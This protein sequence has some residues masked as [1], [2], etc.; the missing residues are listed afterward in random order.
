MKQIYL[1]SLVNAIC[2]LDPF[3]TATFNNTTVYVYMQFDKRHLIIDYKRG[4]G[5]TL[6]NYLS[7]CL[8]RHINKH[9]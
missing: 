8:I 9:H 3:P 7:P 5:A 2:C 4:A 1:A 6:S